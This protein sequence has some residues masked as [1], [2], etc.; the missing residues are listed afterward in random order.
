M[1][2]LKIKL[3]AVGVTAFLLLVGVFMMLG[4]NYNGYRTVV[5]TPNGT[6][7]VKF[8][9]GPYLMW[10]GQSTVYPDFITYDFDKD[11]NN[12]ESRSLNSDGINVRYQ[13]GGTGTIYG[14]ARFK[15][16][17]DEPTMLAMHKS[18]RSPEGIAYKM[19]KPIADEVIV[20]TANL[21]TSDESYM[22]KRAQFGEWARD[23]LV[24]GKYR[25]KL[26]TK[27]VKE[28]GTDKT[29][30]RAVPI[31]ALGTDGLP[32]YQSSDLKSFSVSLT[33][34]QIT[35]FDYEQKTLDQI[36]ARRTATMAII[37]AKAEAERAKQDAITAEQQGLRNVTVAKYE[38]EVEKE[39]AV[40]DAQRNKEVAVIAAVQNVD[41]A[42]QKKKEQEQNKLAMAEYKQA[43][44]LRGEGDAA[45]KRAVIV[46]DGALAQKLATYET[47]MA[48][49]ATEFGK[50]KW[51]PN[52]MMGQQA[53]SGT[54][55]EA[56]NFINLLT[57]KAAKD[58]EL[59][60][61]VTPKPA[62]AK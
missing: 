14:Q 50:Q 29:V 59:D 35:D 18:Y 47:V 58:L 42:E 34:Q 28:E 16:P 45:Y 43:E 55:N 5:Q 27:E 32:Q 23:Q 60:L 2:T 46:A 19:I 15:L 53:G 22:E 24:N 57:T 6:T 41:V 56:A 7:F 62:D 49:F 51:V 9:P 8:T 44:I 26:Q 30:Y 36:Q 52:I 33:S 1:M 48:K 54:S 40:V 10:F 11:N 61:S 3:I 20:L 39:R 25:T 37:T 4:I 31:I 17:D 21:M 38:K 12:N 13:E